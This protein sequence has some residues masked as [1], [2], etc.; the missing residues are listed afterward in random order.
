VPVAAVPPARPVAPG[1][2]S[3]PRRRGAVTSSV[4]APRRG[5]QA[6]GPSSMD[7]AAATYTHIRRD[8]VRIAILAAAMMAI[9]VVL[10]FVLR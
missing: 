4:L 1:A 6:G 10:S 9:I 2:P 8:L 7:L 3:A 5:A